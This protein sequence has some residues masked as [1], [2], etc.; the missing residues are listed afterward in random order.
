[1]AKIVYLWDR[2]SRIYTGST[3]AQPDIAKPGQYLM[4]AFSC[5]DA[6]AAVEEGMANFRNQENTAWETRTAPDPAPASPGQDYLFRDGDWWKYKFTKKEFLLLCGIPQV[7]R[8]NA[9]IS[10]GNPVAK[11]VHDLLFASEYI[12]VSDSATVELVQ[13]LVTDEASNVLTEEQASLIL[14]GQ[15]YESPVSSGIGEE[16]EA[17]N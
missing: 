13:L 11:T 12:D 16:N 7:I 15:K 9:V 2:H 3:Y 10:A 1:M 17:E 14:Q 4:P 5:E 8:L 6:P